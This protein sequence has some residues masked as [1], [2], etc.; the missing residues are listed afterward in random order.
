MRTLQK[1]FVM[2]AALLVVLA[3][4]GI[5]YAVTGSDQA[6]QVKGIAQQPVLV[7]G[8]NKVLGSLV[9]SVQYHSFYST[10]LNL[11]VA[12]DGSGNIV[13][14]SYNRANPATGYITE[15]YQTTDCTGQPY[16]PQREATAFFGASLFDYLLKSANGRYYQ[17]EPG[18]SF[19]N[20]SMHTTLDAGNSCDATTES[21]GFVPLELVRNIPYS[22]PL[23]GPVHLAGQ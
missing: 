20:L 19:T 10:P 18:A 22:D 9:D 8:N 5:A 23:A 17:V 2:F 1:R 11:L 14:P 15:L 21:G 12:V 6:A 4:G 16:Y 13:S 7:D 3:S